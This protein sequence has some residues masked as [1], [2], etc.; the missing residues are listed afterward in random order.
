LL[1]IDFGQMLQNGYVTRAKK[2]GRRGTLFKIGQPEQ[3]TTLHQPDLSTAKRCHAMRQFPFH[4]FY[5]C[6]YPL[7]TAGLRAKFIKVIH[8]PTDCGSGGQT[9]P[10][11]L[12]NHPRFRSGRGKS[13]F[14]RP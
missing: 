3:I 11:K 10:F 8:Y 1:L 14:E 4:S 7:H 9:T 2:I 12:K 13:P 6:L 5:R